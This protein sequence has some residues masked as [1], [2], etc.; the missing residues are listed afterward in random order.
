MNRATGLA[1]I[2]VVMA[3][4]AVPIGISVAQPV[5]WNA[6]AEC[7]SGGNW[8]AD[9]GNG[10]YGGLQISE[11]TWKANGGIGSPA[12]ASPQQQIQVA[13]RVMATQG[14]DA[15][16]KCAAGSN[17]GGRAAPI[18]SLKQFLSALKSADHKLQGGSCWI[19]LRCF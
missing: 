17:G 13:N 7:E 10:F 4:S 9:T 5:D 15:W 2:A 6:L 12:D 11:A 8:T 19:P 16:P 14:P 18:G 1:A 3:A